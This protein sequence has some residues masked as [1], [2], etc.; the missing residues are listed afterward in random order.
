M[1]QTYRTLRG[2]WLKNHRYHG[3]LRAVARCLAGTI[4]I[5]TGLA[6]RRWKSAAALDVLSFSVV[7]WMSSLWGRLMRQA[8]ADL[9]ARMLLGDCSGGIG[10]LQRRLIGDHGVV[11][12]PCLNDHHG[13]KIDLFLD[14]LC[15]APLALICDDDVFWT[16]REPL[17]WALRQLEQNPRVAAVS[18][19]PRP[20][21]SGVLEHQGISRPMG[22][23]CLL[24]RR[25]IWRRERLSF[26]V[27]PPPSSGPQDWFYDTADLAQVELLRRGYDVVIAPPEVRRGLRAFEGVSSW[28]LK[29]QRHSPAKLIEAIAGIAVRQEKAWQTILV[30]RGLARIL[31][32][33]GLAPAPTEL[34][35]GRRLDGAERLLEGELSR[36]RRQRIG[37]EVGEMLRDIQR[38]LA[39]APSIGD[40]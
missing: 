10:P 37:H 7:P 26:R 19:V 39:T 15:R 1:I 36:A 3:G 6:G 28:V 23:Y 24:I 9:E 21:V 12:L 27:A 8:T 32:E 2:N 14:R 16:T 40:S 33:M 13:E 34:V 29:L 30:M 35:A 18:L 5:R 20:E 11:V 25:E 31:A 17:D 38:A 22:S 4:A